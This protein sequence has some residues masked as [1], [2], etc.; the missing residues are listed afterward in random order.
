MSFA[1]NLAEVIRTIPA[2]PR[3]LNATVLMATPH[4]S[5]FPD[6]RH[7]SPHFASIV[8]AIIPF[9]NKSHANLFLFFVTTI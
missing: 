9:D 1:S 2:T 5:R 3:I 7:P 6:S 4:A 8:D